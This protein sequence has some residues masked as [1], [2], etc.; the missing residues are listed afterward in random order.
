MFR[1]ALMLSAF[2]ALASLPGAALAHN[3]VDHADG[4]FEF[5]HPGAAKDVTRTVKISASDYEFS[6]TDLTVSKGETVKFIVTNTSKHMHEFTIGDEDSQLAHR[7]SMAAMG[8]MHDMKGMDGDHAMP[9]NSV[10]VAPG[11]T[12]ELIWTFEGTSNLLFACNFPGH[13]DLGMEG[14]ITVK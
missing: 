11:K 9:S 7:K 8:D 6:P 13:A 12:G 10:H 2:I 3:G 4:H 1:N 14:K 5:G